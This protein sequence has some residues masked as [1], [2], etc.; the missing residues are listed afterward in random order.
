MESFIILT[1]ILSCFASNHLVYIFPEGHFDVA[2][3]ADRPDD[4]YA[5]FH[6]YREVII[7]ATDQDDEF[8]IESDIEADESTEKIYQNF[9]VPRDTYYID[10]ENGQFFSPV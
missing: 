7:E 10:D 4:N 8:W 2:Y 3:D 9:I 1:F 6:M 5:H